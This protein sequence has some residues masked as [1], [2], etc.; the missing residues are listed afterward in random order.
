M[1]D[2]VAYLDVTQLVADLTTISTLPPAKITENIMTDVGKEIEDRARAKAPMKTGKL[3][4]SIVAKYENG[5]LVIDAPV[6]YAMYQEFG[7][8]TRG[9]Y[10]T[11]MYQIKPKNAKFLHFKVGGKDVFAKVVNH[12]GIK[13]HPYLRPATRDAVMALAPKLAAN[14]AL[15]ITKGPNSAL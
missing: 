7:T 10:P 14:G 12:P 5:A 1:T 15:K 2:P 9:E 4:A 3:K 8:G 6:P 13:A 11:G